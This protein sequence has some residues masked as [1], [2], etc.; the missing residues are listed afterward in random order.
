MA[1][2]PPHPSSILKPWTPLEHLIHTSAEPVISAEEKMEKARARAE[3]AAAIEA[4]AA[5]VKAERESKES[6]DAAGS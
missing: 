6:G 3:R 5:A 4:A 2:K 1:R